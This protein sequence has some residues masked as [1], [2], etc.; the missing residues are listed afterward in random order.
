M[1][2]ENLLF[3]TGL[4]H[5]EAPVEY[6]VTVY[7]CLN[8]TTFCFLLSQ[9]ELLPEIGI[10]HILKCKIIDIVFSYFTKYSEEVAVD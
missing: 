3:R 6:A 9:A 2:Q 8:Q 7:V 10:C 1:K 5:A 4:W